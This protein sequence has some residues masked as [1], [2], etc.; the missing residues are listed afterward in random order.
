[1]LSFIYKNCQWSLITMT[2]GWFLTTEINGKGFL[3]FDTMY[4]YFP[5]FSGENGC[6]TH[7]LYKFCHHAWHY[8]TLYISHSASFGIHFKL[9]N[10]WVTSDS[11]LVEPLVKKNLSTLEIHK[12]SQ[13][14]G[15]HPKNGNSNCRSNF[16]WSKKF[17]FQLVGFIQWKYFLSHLNFSIRISKLVY[18][19]ISILSIFFW[20]QNYFSPRKKQSLNY[21]A[22]LLIFEHVEIYCLFVMMSN[23]NS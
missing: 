7:F 1:M 11:L 3:T 6:W 14:L 4:W 10:F 5:S 15:V 12:Y 22:Y 19:L 23:K 9:S 20:S 17:S 13:L 21:I 8:Y 16:D 18:F 2:R